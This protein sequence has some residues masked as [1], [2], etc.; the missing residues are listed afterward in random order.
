MNIKFD[1]AINYCI[2]II[3]GIIFGSAITNMLSDK[4]E[5]KDC[6]CKN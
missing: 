3:L 2:A 5:E 1:K 4:I 6:N